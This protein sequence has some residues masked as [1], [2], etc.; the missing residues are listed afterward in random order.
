M[1]IQCYCM[2]RQ[3]LGKKQ[4]YYNETFNIMFSERLFSG[5]FMILDIKIG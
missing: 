5:G 1:I 3:E 4:N 2:L